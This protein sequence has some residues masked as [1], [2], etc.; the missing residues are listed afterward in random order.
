V[1]QLPTQLYHGYLLDE[2]LATRRAIRESLQQFTQYPP[3]EWITRSKTVL[4]VHDLSQH[5][6]N[7]VVEAG[8]VEAF[9]AA[10]WSDSDDDQRRRDFAELL[11]YCLAEM[12]G[13][14]HVRYQESRG[15]YF[16]AATPD[17]KPRLISYTSVKQKA[18]KE[19]FGP[20]QN[21]KDPTRVAYYRHS[22][23]IGHFV[24]DDDGAWFLEIEPTYHFTFDGKRGDSFGAS[25]LTGIKRLER[26][27]SV[28]GQLHMWRAVLSP[29]PTLFRK[30]Y[31]HLA[32]GDLEKFQLSAGIDDPA[33]L[34]RED[35]PLPAADEVERA[36]TLWD[37]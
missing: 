35:E 26:N 24:R 12:L 13:P 17:L 23:F 5:P 16:F 8:T 11:N 31:P 20:R 36:D 7:K 34:K 33:W 25:R 6:W 9:D 15:Y 19:V 18:E 10:E 21:K 14:Q 32:F 4:S 3:R 27:P 1:S 28:L 22:A 2:Q 30:A 29:P 37:L